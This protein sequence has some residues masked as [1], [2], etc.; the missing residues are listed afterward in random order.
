MLSLLLQP[1]DFSVRVVVIP[2]PEGGGFDDF[3]GDKVRQLPARDP[4]ALFNCIE[5]G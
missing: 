1:D 3:Q 5:S 2:E 4:E